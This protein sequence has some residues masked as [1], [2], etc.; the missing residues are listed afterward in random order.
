MKFLNIFLIDPD[1]NG[2]TKLSCLRDENAIKVTHVSTLNKMALDENNMP[3]CIV[4]DADDPSSSSEDF[5]LCLQ[6]LSVKIP[7]IVTCREGDVS[8][9]VKLMQSGVC[10]LIQKPFTNHRMNQALEKALKHH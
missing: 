3:D 8:F 1:P 7:V 10:D 2:A 9:A 4:I 6:R 5:L